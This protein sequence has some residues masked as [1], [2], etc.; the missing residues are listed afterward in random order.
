MP[1]TAKLAVAVINQ[2]II[3]TSL[4]TGVKGQQVR[5]PVDSCEE[6]MFAELIDC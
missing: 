4:N 6:G 1:V 3:D 2:Y 5:K